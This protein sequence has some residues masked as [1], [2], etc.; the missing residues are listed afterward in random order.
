MIAVERAGAAVGPARMQVAERPGRQPWSTSLR[1]VL[2]GSTIHTDGAQMLRTLGTRGYTHEY[3]VGIRAPDPAEV[4]PGVHITASLLKRWLT[5]TMHFGVQPHQLPYYLDEFTF[6]FN[7][8]TSTKRGLLFTD[9]AAGRRHRPPPAARTTESVATSSREPRTGV[10]VDGGL[11]MGVRGVGGP[12]VL[13]DVRAGAAA[14]DASPEVGALWWQL[15]GLTGDDLPGMGLVAGERPAA[16]VEVLCSAVASV[17]FELARRMAAAARSGSLP[18]VGD[19]AMLLARGWSAGWARR[20]ARAGA[21]AEVHPALGGVWAAGVITSEHVD[22]LA[23]HADRLTTVQMAAVISELGPWWGELSPAAVAAFVARVIRV[24]TPPRDPEPD[25]VGAHEAR[26]VSFALTSDSVVLSGVLPRLEGEA[27]I[28]AIDA[29]AERLR[30]QADHVPASARRAD[31]LVALVNAA[32]ACGS[33]PT[34]GGLPVSVSVTLDSTVLGDQVWTTSRG[35]TLTAAE[36]R[37]T[38]CDAL[39]TPILIDSG[40]CPDTR[41]RMAHRR[42]ASAA[43]RC[44]RAALSQPTDPAGNGQRRV[45]PRRTSL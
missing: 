31:G 2:P 16:D 44:P 36:H 20:L 12:P 39:V 26:S 25:E 6:R 19:G 29:F 43:A 4:L 38:A 8:R 45:P 23:R 3:V 32:H 33:I 40:H 10:R 13:G 22:A 15:A 35:H 34:R 7:R 27:V 24:L 11:G 5:G 37:F 9:S 28:A 21:F 18:L 1:T 17:E 41:G 42:R 14:R 30:S